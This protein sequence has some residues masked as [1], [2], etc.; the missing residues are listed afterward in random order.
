M[1]KSIALIIIVIVILFEPAQVRAEEESLPSAT[2][3]GLRMM[4][5]DNPEWS[6][7]D[8]DSRDWPLSKL[9]RGTAFNRVVI[10]NE[11]GWL[12]SE[13]FSLPQSFTT[14]P[15]ALY[16][17]SG[18]SFQ[19]FWNGVMVGENGHPASNASTEI[20][21]LSDTRFYIPPELIRETDNVLALRYS[22]H[23]YGRLH[24]PLAI[25]ARIG[26]YQDE[27][28]DRLSSHVPAL[29]LLGAVGAAIHFFCC[30]ISEQAL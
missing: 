13:P 22:A 5:G 6:K 30:I 20:D 27:K 7:P 4:Q 26:P 24:L 23:G 19:V 12:R 2:I 10:P 25:E 16:F 15:M 3:F 29:L 18:A 14:H 21:G 9:V 8:F 11:I 17:I 1:L 28:Y